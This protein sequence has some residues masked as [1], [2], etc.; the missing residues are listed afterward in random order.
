MTDLGDLLGLPTP[1]PARARRRG[2]RRRVR[3]RHCGRWVYVDRLVY[4]YGEDC[5]ETLGLT[6]DRRR[7]ADTGQT[8][9]DL[10]DE[11]RAAGDDQDEPDE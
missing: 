4:G 10:L 3:C 7:G 11:L 8:G 6:V 2:G 1:P 5:A 9:R